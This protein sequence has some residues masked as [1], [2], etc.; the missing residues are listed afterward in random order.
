M[1]KT[2]QIKKSFIT[3]M[4]DK[5]G[6]FL[7]ASRIIRHY[8][9]NIVRVSYNKAVDVN[10]L[11]LDIMAEEEDLQKI[12][13]ELRKIG[14]IN[15]KMTETK[16]IEVAIKI[17][18][19]P[20]AVLPVLEI[21]NAYNINISYMNSSASGAPYQDFKMGLLIENPVIV[22]TLLDE[23]SGVYKI[24]I[25]QCDIKEEHLDNT[26]FY[27]RLANEMQQL[28]DLNAEQTMRFITE[29]NRILQVLQEEGEDAGK[30]FRYIKRFAHYVSSNRGEKF[31]VQTDRFKLQDDVCLYAFQP[32]CGSNTYVIDAAGEL[33]FI[34]SGYAVYAEEMRRIFKE[35]WPDFDRRAKR[36]YITHADVD[37]CG[38]LSRF[39][40]ARII[41]NAKSAESLRRQRGGFADY[42]ENTPL[43]YGY[44]RISQII[45]GYEPPDDCRFEIM[46]P[47]TPVFHDDLLSI[48]S[49]F[50]SNIVFDIYEGSGG[51]LDG[52]VI[53]VNR[54]L[55]ILF[56]GDLFVNI[57]GFSD[58]M[59]E[60]NALAPYLMKSVNTNSDKASK[61]RGDIIEMADGISRANASPC[62][63]FGGHGPVYRFKNGT[64]APDL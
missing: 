55:G 62:L 47:Q 64:D 49:M 43:T 23:I 16:I 32:P 10:T 9:G 28:L 41:L 59:K 19:R 4:P 22:K 63:I 57:G 31:R 48:G 33:V 53:Y 39:K 5:S 1:T 50:V 14:Y 46:D 15:S 20:G 13:A 11:F 27:I 54:S 2:N 34:D 25:I 8:N 35:I 17:P 3:R 29:S 30:I 37:H 45:S 7:R 12:D 61:M 36:M 60:F 24:D 6:A 52:E 51:H 40:D 21:L 56:T 38:L 26:D 44:S 42:R 18:D 58:E